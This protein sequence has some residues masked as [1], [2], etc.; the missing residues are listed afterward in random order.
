VPACA[1]GPR[2]LAPRI[3]AT[4]LCLCR[5][6]RPLGCSSE[7]RRARGAHTATTAVIPGIPSHL[8]SGHCCAHCTRWTPCNLGV[9]YESGEGVDQDEAEAAKWFC[10]AAE[11][12]HSGAQ[13]NLGICYESGQG[14][15]QDVTEAAK[16]FR[17]AIEQGDNDAIQALAR[18]CGHVGDI[19]REEEEEEEEAAA[20][21]LACLAKAIPVGVP[22][23]GSSSAAA[24]VVGGA[25]ITSDHGYQLRST[26]GI[27]QLAV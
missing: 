27:L 5:W 3:S 25:A 8:R 16:W 22:I 12:G 17:K 2:H 4:R 20:A 6:P 23:G 7:R 10:K 9:C 1:P 14:V 13:Y 24:A 11:Q 19:T 18:C 15:D 21:G 26:Y